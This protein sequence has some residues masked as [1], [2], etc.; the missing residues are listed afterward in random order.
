MRALSAPGFTERVEVSDVVLLLL[1][2]LGW[3]CSEVRRSDCVFPSVVLRF[4]REAAP[5][6]DCGGVFEPASEVPVRVV[7]WP[8]V[9]ALSA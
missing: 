6:V 1:D 4:T 7:R 2:E 8:S 5:F 9:I 3:T